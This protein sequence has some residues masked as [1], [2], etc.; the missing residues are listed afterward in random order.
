LCSYELCVRAR[1]QCHSFERM[2]RSTVSPARVMAL[3]AATSGLV[4]ALPIS[5]LAQDRSLNPIHDQ[6]P[7]PQLPLTEPEAELSPNDTLS[8]AIADAYA[9]NPDL[10]AQRYVLRAT[11]DEVGVALSQTRPR[12]DL[13]VSGRYDLTLP[14]EI[15]NAARPISDRLNNPNIERDELNSQLAVEQ[16]LFTGGRAAG[17]LRVARAQ[18]DA[19]REALRGIE[20]DILVNLVA[21]YSDVRRDGRIV[22]IRSR[23]LKW[24]DTT[25]NEISARREAGELTR[26]DLAQAETQLEIARVQLN[27]ALAQFEASRA[28]FVAIV[29]RA[30]GILAPEPDLPN[31]PRSADEAFRVAEANNP[32]L[33]AALAAQRAA[34][35]R[36]GLAKS[37]GRPVLS[38]R[39]T[40]GTIGPAL[41]FVPDD[42]DIIFTGGATL[43][44]PL[45]E[46]GRIKSRIAQARNEESAE[47]LRVEATRRGVIQAVVNSW[48]QWVTAERNL[49]AQELQRKAAAIFYEGSLEE[50]REGLRS[51]FDVLFAQNSLNEAEID[52]LASRRESYVAQAALLR[53]IGMLEADRLLN[54]APPY[55]ADAYLGRVEGRNSVP[56]GPVV[57]ALDRLTAPAG[58]PQ[59][60]TDFESTAQSARFEAASPAPAPSELIISPSPQVFVGPEDKSA[61]GEV[62]R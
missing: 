29:G 61:L 54:N 13:Q 10:A 51:T 49:G 24:L 9:T 26:T 30:P 18:S 56:W 57:R 23:N 3:C 28:S 34:E 7:V 12:I 31:L 53:Q 6:Y 58:K 55:D 32:D 62:E 59:T 40:A 33:A 41:P 44:I 14:G 5:V 36:I 8:A 4:I 45:S 15:T 21:A 27:A 20:G 19:G 39:G 38:L 46:G 2:G 16:P 43:T 1:P 47:R 52:L 22:A 60:I 17:A 37:E 11:D 48:N 42:Q 25:L 50:Y 35:E